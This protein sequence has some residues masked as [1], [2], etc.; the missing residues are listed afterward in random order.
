MFYGTVAA[1][2][3]TLWVSSGRLLAVQILQNPGFEQQLTDWTTS[4]GT[5]VYTADSTNPHSGV[6]SAKGIETNAGS[7]GQLYQNLT[8]LLIPGQPY[9]MSGWIMTQNVSGGAGFLLGLEYAV[10]LGEGTPA[11]GNIPNGFIGQISGTTPWTFYQKT[12]TLP[13]MPADTSALEFAADFSDA[14]GTAWF[15]DLTLS[16]PEVPEPAS[17]GVLAVGTLMFLGRR[18]RL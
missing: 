6:Y 11:D 1:I 14:S 17:I 18:R 16:G 2:I 5:A 12:V 13:A 7:L 3:L 8:G 4:V 15:D 9:T 10:S